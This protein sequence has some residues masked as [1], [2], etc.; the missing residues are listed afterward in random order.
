MTYREKYDAAEKASKDFQ[1]SSGV[2]FT[3]AEAQEF[4]ASYFEG[5]MVSEADHKALV[6][7]PLDAPWN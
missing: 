1:L 3:F 6:R 5:L 7:K 4:K 2:D